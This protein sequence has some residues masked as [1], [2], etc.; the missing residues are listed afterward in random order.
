[1]VLGAALLLGSVELRER[2]AAAAQER[3]LDAVVDV[4]VRPEGGGTEYDPGTR[5]AQLQHRLLLSNDGPRDVTVTGAAVAGYALVQDEVRVPAGRS[6]PLLLERS[7]TCSPSA[8]PPELDTDTLVL[9][10][11]TAAGP[12]A[13]D[14]ALDVPIAADESA[15]ACG[16][17]PLDEAASVAVTGAARR[18]DLLELGLEV[19]VASARPVDLLGVEVGPGLHVELRQ[20]G[21]GVVPLP[22]AL[23]P[24]SGPAATTS[25]YVLR[26]GA[27]DCDAAIGGAGSP[28]LALL[29]RGEDG[30][31][32]RVEALYELGYLMALLLDVC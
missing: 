3:R 1:M 10:L 17:V 7:V 23:P 20:V 26:I 2:R 11:T 15:R 16:L 18:G 32:A 24:A 5:R 13:V 31:Q 28:D 30:T 9:Q 8:P 21:G 22:L 6:T 25:S 29:L 14:V 4:S 12:R 27:T 19:A